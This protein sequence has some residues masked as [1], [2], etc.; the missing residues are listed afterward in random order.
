MEYKYTKEQMAGIEKMLEW[1][2]SK[3]TTMFKFTDER[4]GKENGNDGVIIYSNGQN[5]VDWMTQKVTDLEY[6]EYDKVV[7]NAIRELYLD[8]Q[9]EGYMVTQIVHT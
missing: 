2:H 1:F 9:K 7:W 6:T 8:N 4:W 3:S 5:M